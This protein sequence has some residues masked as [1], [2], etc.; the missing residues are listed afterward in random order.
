MYTVIKVKK[1][2]AHLAL[3]DLKYLTLYQKVLAIPG[4]NPSQF[5]TSAP[6]HVAPLPIGQFMVSRG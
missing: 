2:L 6:L 5:L 3:L 4:L 1:L